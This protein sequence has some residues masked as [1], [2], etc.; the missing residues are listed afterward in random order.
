GEFELLPLL[1]DVLRQF[2]DALI[3]ARDGDLA[4]LVMKLGKELR[5]DADRI[6]GGSAI[7]A[8]MKIY[9]GARDGDLILDHASEARTE[10]RRLCVRHARVADESGIAGKLRLVL[11]EERDEAR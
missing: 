5:E 8:G 6:G 11:L 3:E 7:G 10:G 4:V 9:A 2:A 1:L